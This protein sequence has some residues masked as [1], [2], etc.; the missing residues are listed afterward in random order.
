MI[1]TFGFDLTEIKIHPGASDS[2]GDQLNI[3]GGKRCNL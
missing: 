3:I 2:D 1:R